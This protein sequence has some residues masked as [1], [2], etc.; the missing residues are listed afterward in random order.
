MQ[1]VFT[2]TMRRPDGMGD[3]T[4]TITRE[5]GDLDADVKARVKV[6]M[7]QIE[8]FAGVQPMAS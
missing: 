8:K 4:A 3:V 5:A 6:L 2:V 7:K 1:E